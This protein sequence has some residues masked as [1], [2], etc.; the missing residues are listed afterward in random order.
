MAIIL[1][2]SYIIIYEV[3]SVLVPHTED[4]KSRICTRNLVRLATWNIPQGRR[5]LPFSRAC[6]CAGSQGA[7]YCGGCA[8]VERT[9]NWFPWLPMNWD[10]DH[11]G[12]ELDDAIIELLP[13]LKFEP[14]AAQTSRA[15]APLALPQGR[16][17]IESAATNLSGF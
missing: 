17:W 2:K 4:H 8:R 9:R 3:D 1:S 16:R 15:A 7:L 11:E 6:P 5:A 12:M 14:M 10:Q 13:N